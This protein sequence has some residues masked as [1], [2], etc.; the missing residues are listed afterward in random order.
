MA[1][2]DT[3]EPVD[4]CQPLAG[5]KHRANWGFAFSNL[6]Y[7]D[8]ANTVEC[9]RPS[10]SLHAVRRISK[11][12]INSSKQFAKPAASGYD[13]SQNGMGSI[14]S[15]RLAPTSSMLAVARGFSTDPGFASRPPISVVGARRFDG[16]SGRCGCA[17]PFPRSFEYTLLGH[18]EAQIHSS[19]ASLNSRRPMGSN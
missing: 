14:W 18:S 17:S 2:L 8:E 3:I 15:V 4:R 6:S 12:Q 13:N 11:E 1:R 19:F 9:I 7:D 10:T 5:R 16:S